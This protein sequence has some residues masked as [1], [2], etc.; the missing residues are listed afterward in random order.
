MCTLSGAVAKAATR[1]VGEVTPSTSAS[2]HRQ[3]A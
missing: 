3:I 2:A 1:H